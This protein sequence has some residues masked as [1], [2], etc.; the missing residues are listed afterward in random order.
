MSAISREEDHGPGSWAVQP[1]TDPLTDPRNVLAESGLGGYRLPARSADRTSTG[2]RLRVKKHPIREIA[3]IEV[4][5]R[6]GD[7]VEDLDWAIQLALA[8][9]PRG[10]ACDLAGVLN[11][12]EP[13]AL[14]VLATSGRHVRDWGGT[15][16]AVSSPDPRVRDVLSA[17][18]LGGRLTV[19]KSLPSALHA[20]LRTPAPAVKRLRLA[21]HPTA[22]RAARDFVT[23]AL[24]GWQLAALTPSACLVVSELV[25]NAILHDGTGGDI[26]LSVALNADSVRLT[27]RDHTP[28]APQ[29]QDPD[30]GQHG[31]GLTI[32]A[33][34]SH[35]LGVLPTTDGGKVVW[36]VLDLPNAQ[37]TTLSPHP[38]SD[39][40]H[41]TVKHQG[42]GPVPATER[43]AS[44]SVRPVRVRESQRYHA[45]S[46][47]D[48][49][50]Y[51]G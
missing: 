13:D 50:N 14:A 32:V 30:L 31:R 6:L 48:P 42:A 40:G 15:P 49:C 7:I 39:A 25:T 33:G 2:P 27:V 8:T 29:Q 41:E 11:G 5:G 36:A 34:L 9:G 26:D 12:A 47:D 21:P 43:K 4:A 1:L 51:L 17:H 16:V 10:V 22:P 19:T 24:Q 44:R 28:T 38:R 45:R 46:Y 3:V 37:P 20:V 23:D 35:A 18:P